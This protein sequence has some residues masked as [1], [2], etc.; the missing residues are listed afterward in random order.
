[1]NNPKTIYI[2]FI[3]PRKKEEKDDIIFTDKKALIQILYS[4]K[5]E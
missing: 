2:L 4:E 5:K 1:M 3:Y